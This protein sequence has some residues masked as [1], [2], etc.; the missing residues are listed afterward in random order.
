M[1]VGVLAFAGD[2]FGEGDEADED[3][4]AWFVRSGF[5]GKENSGASEGEEEDTIPIC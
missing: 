3:E 5:V 2:A 4:D 1:Y